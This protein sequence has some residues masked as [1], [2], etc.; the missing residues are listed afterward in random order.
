MMMVIIYNNEYYGLQ[1]E[2][3]REG[4]KGRIKRI[5]HILLLTERETEMDRKRL[6]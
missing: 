5:I 6:R 2:G 1:K 3:E 4:R